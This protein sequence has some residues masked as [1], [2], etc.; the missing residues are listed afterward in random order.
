MTASV[1]Y[2]TTDNRGTSRNILP[3]GEV[4]VIGC[5]AVLVS[6]TGTTAETALYTVAIP[7][8]I[9]GPNSAMRI[10][11]TW[12]YTNSANNK[13][14]RLRIGTT[15]SGAILYERTRT[16]SVTESPLIVIA[17]RGAQNLQANIYAPLGSYGNNIVS[18]IGTNNFNFATPGL[19]LYLTGQLANTLETISMESLMV[20]VWN[21]YA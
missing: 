17:N 1:I 8:G 21:P 19:N 12:S 11:P 5:A 15:I 16:A 2:G 20:S 14:L 18:A 3:S 6:V 10:E 9:M 4:S 7:D 13:L